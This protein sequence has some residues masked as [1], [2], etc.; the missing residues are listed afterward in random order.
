MAAELQAARHEG[1]RLREEA[2]KAAAARAQAEAAAAGGDADAARGRGPAVALS[3]FLAP[4][5]P[6]APFSVAW[7]FPACSMEGYRAG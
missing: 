3:F 4:S 2:D 1:M 7:R 6:S 5:A